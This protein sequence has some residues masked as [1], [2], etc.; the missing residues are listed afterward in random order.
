MVSG[1]GGGV[2]SL[3]PGAGG[4]EPDAA[5]ESHGPESPDDGAES[6][7]Q[8]QDEAVDG[9][10]MHH[11]HADKHY[12]D[13]LFEWGAVEFGFVQ[14]D[15]SDGAGCEIGG[16]GNDHEQGG[17]QTE[18]LGIEF[19]E[20]VGVFGEDKIGGEEADDHVDDRGAD[21]GQG[22]ELCL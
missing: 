12:V 21:N 3:E 17:E 11:G 16:D 7:E 4:E 19:D 22:D 1:R 8:A 15:F 18:D 14:E 6:V 2:L 10:G 5:S 20:S 9:G 13:A